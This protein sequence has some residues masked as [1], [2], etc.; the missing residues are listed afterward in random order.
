MYCGVGD[1]VGWSSSDGCSWLAGA[2]GSSKHVESGVPDDST[3]GRGGSE[4]L[5]YSCR[6]GWWRCG[7]VDAGG[8]RHRHRGQAKDDGETAGDVRG[9]PQI[10]V[11]VVAVLSVAATGEPV[12]G[13]EMRGVPPSSASA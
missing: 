1:V 3:N 8:E 7:A 2:A 12:E 5:Q 10:V 6:L 9:Q 4:A 13:T 11:V